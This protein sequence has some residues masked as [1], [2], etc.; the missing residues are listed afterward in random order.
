MSQDP[1]TLAGSSWSTSQ[2]TTSLVYQRNIEAL[3]AAA[4]RITRVLIFEKNW[5]LEGFW[6]RARLGNLQN[7]EACQGAPGLGFAA[8]VY[9]VDAETPGAGFVRG[10]LD[11][12]QGG[13][14]DPTRFLDEGRK[15]AIEVII[16]I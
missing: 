3:V 6:C 2:V 14:N 11:G 16:A 7:D 5:Q 10:W 1:Q 13:T 15:S 12:L 9:L 4:D 8:C